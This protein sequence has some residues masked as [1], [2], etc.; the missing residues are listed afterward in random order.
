MAKMFTAL[1]AL[2]LGGLF[3]SSALADAMGPNGDKFY[4]EA[5]HFENACRDGACK[6]PYASQ[7]VYVQ[8]KNF[9]K[10]TVDTKQRL[11]AIAQDQ[12]S[13]WD[14]TILEGDYVATGRTRLDSVVAFFKKDRL[15]GYKITY[16]KK[17][18]FTGE[19][20]YDGRN[21]ETLQGCKEGRIAEGSYVSADTLT[22]FSDE[23][24]YAEF[25]LSVT[26]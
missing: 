7:I 26:H 18:W 14:D 15:V 6:P 11:R 2:F 25:F 3:T 22:Y 1:M 19:C 23:E 17:A 9:D 16:S 8:D 5:A 12:T 4:E 13:V 10:L 20:H 24:R 21:R